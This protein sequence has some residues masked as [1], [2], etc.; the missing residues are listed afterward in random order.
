MENINVI[1]YT[2][3]KLIECQN[4]IYIKIDKVEKDIRNIKK[5]IKNLNLLVNNIS[6]LTDIYKE[7]IGIDIGIDISNTT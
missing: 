4:K 6:N 1:I 3:K 2:L 7:D 5:N